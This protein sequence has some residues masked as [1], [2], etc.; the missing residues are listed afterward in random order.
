M[1]EQSFRSTP[2]NGT[3]ET[4][5]RDVLAPLFRRRRLVAVSFCGILLG[6]IVAAFILSNTYEARME[7]LVDRERMDPAVT[8]E[9][10]SQT[11][12]PAATV[13][14]EEINSEVQLLQSRDL[15]EKVVVA[16]GLQDVE[17]RSFLS[18]LMPKQ[19]EGYYVSKAALRLGKKLDIEAMTKTNLIAVSYK[20]SDPKLAFGVMNALSNLYLEKHVSVHRPTGSFDLFSVEVEKYRQALQD[21]ETRLANFGRDEGVAAP[22]IVRGD[23]GQQVANSIASFHQAQQAIAA[24]DQRIRD[25]EAQL[26]TTPARSAT[27]QAS[28]AADVLLQG[29]QASL[30]A[31]QL[32]RTQLAMKYDESYPLVVEAD[33]EI[34]QT[35]AMIAE[36]QKTQYVNQ[37]TDRDP[38]YELLREDISKTQA[39]LAAQKATAAA[40]TNSIQS[41]KLQMVDLD[42]KAV[43]Q[44]GLIRDAKANEA[45]YL[46]YLSKR[47]Q[48]RTS[49]F[50]DQKRIAN[51]AIAVPPSVPELPAYSPFLI[52]LIGLVLA[53]GVSVGAAFV[54]EYLDPSFR[55]PA[56]VMDILKM[57]VLASMPKKVA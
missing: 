46:L 51:V 23:L 18:T 37:T 28:N 5:L 16:N 41:L 50:L 31:S 36:A 9:Q 45:N 6:A 22:D 48:E 26:K 12:P 4:T 35:K 30:L 56:E 33:Q 32:K 7:I 43:K 25:E 15:L 17:K 42:Q 20:S 52:L 34:A 10:F 2:A 24:D 38:T 47:E 13:T 57:P 49:D 11:A 29:L 27:T 19:D 3:S 55:T 21:S 1:S 44:T 40:L 39:D 14:E 53:V 54:A 8:A